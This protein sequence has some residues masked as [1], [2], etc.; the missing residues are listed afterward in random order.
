MRLVIDSNIFVS[1]L[2]PKDYF[3]SECYPIFEKLL[4]FEIESICP[5][6]VL[7]ETICALRRRTNSEE[8]ANEYYRNLVILP[9]INWL[10]VNLELAE[11]ACMLGARTGLKGG[12]A[13]ILQVAEQYGVPIL[14]K[15]KE[16]KDK[17]PMGIIV[18]EP[19]ELK[20]WNLL[21]SMGD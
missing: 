16:I 8:I 13:I 10:D 14:T 5:V 21:L 18:F 7:V 2:D 12:D 17:A 6:I 4:N 1:S 3:H 19:E 15:D 9:S 20:K 11:K